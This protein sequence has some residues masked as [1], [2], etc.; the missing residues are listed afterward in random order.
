MKIWVDAD[1]CPVAVKDII[2]RAAHRK[3][4]ETIFVANKILPLMMSPYISFVQVDTTPDAADQYIGEHAIEGD[5]VV[6]QDIPLAH[7]LVPMNVVVLSPRGLVFT[8]DN[9]GER[10]AVRNLM[11]DLRDTGETTG[12]PKPFGDKERREFASAFDRALTKLRI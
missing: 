8:P 12:G 3:T 1:A 9:I 5:L 2:S 11:Q 10:I 6:T 4:I 7:I